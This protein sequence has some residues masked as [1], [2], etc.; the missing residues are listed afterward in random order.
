MLNTKSQM[1][2]R[3]LTMKKFYTMLYILF[4]S[5]FIATFTQAQTEKATVITPQMPCEALMG[6][7][8]SKLPDAA[9]QLSSAEEVTE[10]NLSYCKVIGYSAPQIQFE[11]RLPLSTWTG[12][13]LQ[14]GCGGFC[15]SEEINQKIQYEGNFGPCTPENLSEFV[16]GSSNSGHVGG[17]SQWAQGSPQ[18]RIDWAYRSE[19]VL[20]TATKEIIRTFYGREATFKYFAGCS[21]GG[22]QGLMLAQRY[23]ED[24]DGILVGA[25]G[26]AFVALM[27]QFAW[28]ARA[29]IDE[30]SDSIFTSEALT[31]LHDAALASCDG[32][33][34]LEDGLIT[35]PRA[36]TFEPSVIEC[37]D[38]N[39]Q[40]CLTYA[41]VE[42]ARKVYQGPVA[43]TGQK[44][45]PG[46]L[47]VGSEL[48]WNFLFFGWNPPYTPGF[49]ESMATEYLGYLAT[50]DEP[51]SLKTFTFDEATF[52]KLSELSPLYD[53][54]DPDLSAFRDA[55]GKLILW[56]GWEDAFIPA[57]GAIGYYE[58]VQKEMGGLEKTEEFAR[59]YLI[60]GLA[61][62]IGGS[63][64][65]KFDVFTPLIEWVERDT[66]PEEIVVTQGNSETRTR[67]VYPY[68]T[69]ARY[70]GLGN[71]DEASS[72]QPSTSR[73]NEAE[74]WLGQ[75]RSDFQQWCS[76]EGKTLQCQRAPFRESD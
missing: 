74:P 71:P 68:P 76:V 57:Q 9:T 16:I 46:G 45:A 63:A 30:K 10:E 60:P 20:A 17:D 55:G 56:H 66:A 6:Q 58:A 53:A 13:Y 33:D 70:E 36:C 64:Q 32:E 50:W 54:T 18:L 12:R 2:E 72:F 7:D 41:Q 52:N 61:H 5:L 26:H 65:T 1:I 11:L 22:R 34:G 35:D 28:N 31:V 43:S 40:G 62:C 25:P 49:S 47:P 42:T 73:V 4:A 15:G 69:V 3:K 27:T 23:P 48:E 59:L 37:A 44:L 38:E 75:Y 29:N 39:G 8:F 21:N 67:P 51:L 14:L 24:F 19:H